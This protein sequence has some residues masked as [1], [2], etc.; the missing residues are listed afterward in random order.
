[1]LI[2]RTEKKKGTNEKLFYFCE[3]DSGFNQQVYELKPMDEGSR[4]IVD[5]IKKLHSSIFQYQIESVSN[6]NKIASLE[7]DIER[8]QKSWFKKVLDYFKLKVFTK[9][10]EEI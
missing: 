5:H 4:K 7:S 8:L 9:Y 3:F 6:R 10:K 1:M 2:L